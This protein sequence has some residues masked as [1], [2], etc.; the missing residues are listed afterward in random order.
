[1]QNRRREGA[2]GSDMFRLSMW[3]LEI[4]EFVH[5]M[6]A[7][8]TNILKAVRSAKIA[9]KVPEGQQALKVERR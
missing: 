5:N 6:D 9:L 1:M 4:Q 2:R 3:I 8:A 7:R